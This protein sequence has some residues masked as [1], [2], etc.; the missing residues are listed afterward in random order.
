MPYLAP[1]MELLKQ[2][3]RYTEAEIMAAVLTS[4]YTIFIK[5]DAPDFGASTE[6]APGKVKDMEMGPG[7]INALAPGEEVQFPNAM[8]PN[9][10]FDPFVMSILRRDRC[11]VGAAVRDPGEAFHRFLFRRP[12]RTAR[13]MEVL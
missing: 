2:L 4:F 6:T 8:R 3:D 1:V 10:G 11:R 7:M 13:G 12:R 5:T 9:A